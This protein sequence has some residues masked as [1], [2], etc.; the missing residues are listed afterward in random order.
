MKR[1]QY[2]ILLTLVV[3]GAMFALVQ[4]AYAEVAVLHNVKTTGECYIREPG[5]VNFSLPISGNNLSVNTIV[6]VKSDVSHSMATC[7][8]VLLGSHTLILFPGSTVRLL[9]EGIYPLAGR[10]ELNTASSSESLQ[11]NTRKFSAAYNFGNLLV[12]VTPDSGTY[13]ALRNKGDVWF[14]DS[15][16]K[17]FQLQPGQQLLFPLFGETIE[18][19][20]LSGFWT[21]SPTSFAAVRPRTIFPQKSMPEEEDSIASFSV[22]LE[23]QARSDN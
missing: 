18:Q 15:A 20:R 10:F 19:D 7:S 23:D 5:Q 22:K 13:A 21:A 8:T 1:L 9:A 11:I 2:R 17:I 6:T 14:K 4:L 16:R 12:E 3:F